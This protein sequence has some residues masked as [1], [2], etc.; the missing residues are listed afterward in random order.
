MAEQKVQSDNNTFENIQFEKTKDVYDVT[1]QLNKDSNAISLTFINKTNIKTYRQTFNKQSINKITTKCQ[2]SVSK[3]YQFI[4]DQL[5]S[6]EYISKLCRI[7]IC[8][9]ADTADYQ[10]KQFDKMNNIPD[11]MVSMQN[12]ENNMEGKDIMNTNNAKQQQSISHLLFLLH[13]CDS[14]Y[15][16]CN[17]CFIIKQQEMNDIDKLWLKL[18]DIRQEN[19][20]VKAEL[21]KLKNNMEEKEETKPLIIYGYA[22]R[23]GHGPQKPYT[24]QTPIIFSN[25]VSGMRCN[26]G[27]MLNPQNGRFTAPIG[28]IYTFT[29]S[30]WMS[31]ANTSG[32]LWYN[33]N[34]KREQTFASPIHANS[35]A[36]VGSLT[37][38][39]NKDDYIDFRMY[40]PTGGKREI[41]ENVH[42]TFVRWTLIQGLQKST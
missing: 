6:K 34:E 21:N 3:L 29:V 12:M 24:S 41:Y 15:I 37:L 33:Y 40:A 1:V 32:Q 26:V 7:F 38:E 14:K 25:V 20:M 2:L 18:N 10:R 16:S 19:E 11:S 23:A 13:F 9:D 30:V 17:Y 39:I 28:G 31:G 35:E 36:F 5:S 27:N 4:M 42:H 22:D 8:H